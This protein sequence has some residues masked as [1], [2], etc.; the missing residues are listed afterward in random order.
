MPAPGMHSGLPTDDAMNLA[1]SEG[2]VPLFEKVRA[3]IAEEVDPV[4]EEFFRLGTA[5]PSTGATARAS[6]SCSTR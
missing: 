3:F 5:G 4:T 2:A 6:S 1:M